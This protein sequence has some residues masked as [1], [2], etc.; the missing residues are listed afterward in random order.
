MPLHEYS[1]ERHGKF[2]VL[3]IAPLSCR[4]PLKVRD[5]KLT[6]GR[7]GGTSPNVALCPVCGMPG[8]RLVSTFARTPGRWGADK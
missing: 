5:G 4:S 3:R 8:L 7:V 1:C 2:E 6:A